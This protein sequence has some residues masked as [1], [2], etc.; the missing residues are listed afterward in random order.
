MGVVRRTFKN[1]CIDIPNILWGGGSWTLTVCRAY[2]G[3]CVRG[4][5]TRHLILTLRMCGAAPPL[6]TY[7][8]GA[9]LSRYTNVFMTWWL[10][11]WACR[12][13]ETTSLN[14]GHQRA[15]SSSPRWY[16]SMG[17]YGGMIS[18]E[19]NSWF[20]HQSSLAIL[21]ADTSGSKQGDRAKE[22]MNLALR[23]IFVHISLVIF[24][25]ADGLAFHP[26]KCVLRIFIALKSLSPWP[27][28]NSRILGRMASALTITPPRRRRDYTR[29]EMSSCL[30]KRRNIFS[31]RGSWLRTEMS[32]LRRA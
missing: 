26:K 29:T 11:D 15:Y 12:W 6:P 13:S 8:H 5:F 20:V 3:F 31:C 7:F 18:R 19:E 16:M 27:G 9:L 23:S 21:P 2:R 28:L 22:I 24:Y 30:I 32:S 17:N 10:I 14:C 1:F 25:R 4:S